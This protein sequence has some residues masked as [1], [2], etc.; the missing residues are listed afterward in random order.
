[1]REN[2]ADLRHIFLNDIPLMDVRAPVEFAKGAFGQSVNLPLM[3]D[4][5]REAVGTAYKQQGQQAAIE[6]GH[7][8]VSGS[9]KEARIEGW[10]EFVR[11]QPEG[12][13]YCFRGGL[14]SQITQQW[15]KD[16]AGIPYPRVLGGYKAMRTFLIDTIECAVQECELVV[17]GGLTGSGKT[18]VLA[19][20][21]NALDLEGHANHRGSSF[22]KRVSAQPGQIDFE[23]ALA[24]DIL[25]KRHRGA[26]HFVLEDEGRAIG[27][28]AVPLSLF[29][30][31]QAAPLVWLQ[32]SVESRVERILKDYVIDLCADFVAVHGAEEGFNAFAERLRQS[33]AS[34]LRRLGGERY[35]RLAVIMDS[36][37]Q[38]QQATGLVDAHRQ[39]IEQ[40][41]TEYYDPMYAY[42]RDS[43]SER[44]EFAGDQAAVRDYL[45]QRRHA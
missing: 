39:W 29:R 1:M 17:V 27:S 24:V 43:K 41:L 25:K 26:E 37:L 32:D 12:Y 34:N 44:I 19:G 3:N 5:E 6:L 36:A 18:E 38:M 31:M 9:T 2:S 13:L 35:N 14:R 23:N 8:L 45:L 15:L 28:R 21:S 10:A 30:Q 11:C 42:Q 33:L 22:G 7:Q 40:L 16:I 20:L 4:A